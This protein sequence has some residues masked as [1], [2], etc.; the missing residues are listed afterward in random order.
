MLYTPAVQ[1]ELDEMHV[2]RTVHGV[3]AA[4]VDPDRACA[5]LASVL[6][7]TAQT[8]VLVCIFLTNTARLLEVTTSTLF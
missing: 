1:G 2:A 4:T 3:A 7:M 6:F 5:L 8:G